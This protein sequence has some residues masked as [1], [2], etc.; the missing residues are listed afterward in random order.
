MSSQGAR[1]AEREEMAPGPGG[2]HRP[3]SLSQDLSGAAWCL[4][5]PRRRGQG[6]EAAEYEAWPTLTGV[7]VLGRAAEAN[8]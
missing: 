6:T 8:I 1:D 7:R 2:S 5:R 3:S 4:R